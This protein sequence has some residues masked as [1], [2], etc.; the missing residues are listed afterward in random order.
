MQLIFGVSK[1][2]L[3]SFRSQV[4]WQ[5]GA[6]VHSVVYRTPY[7]QAGPESALSVSTFYSGD[8]RTYAFLGLPKFHMA[9]RF[10]DR[11]DSALVLLCRSCP[12]LETL[13]V[14]E[15]ISTATVLLLA[16]HGRSLRQF[17]VRGN[18]VVKKCD[19]PRNPDWS[20][21]FYSWL[22][23]TSQSYDAVCCEVSQILGFSWAPLT[24]KEFKAVVL[25]DP[26]GDPDLIWDAQSGRECPLPEHRLS[27][28]WSTVPSP[29]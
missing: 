11:P 23:H 29:T 13:V 14:R 27:F 22:R 4:L 9:K 10:V 16:H 2:A 19:W 5:E 28:S 20:D 6:P 8:I 1:S 18:A 24:D 7:S 17:V 15:R 26:H 12:R 21:E 25:R 3:Q